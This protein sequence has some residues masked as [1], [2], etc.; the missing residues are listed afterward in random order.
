M[1]NSEYSLEYL[2][3]FVSL[4]WMTGYLSF[5]DVCAWHCSWAWPLGAGHG[6]WSPSIIRWSRLPSAHYTARTWPMGWAGSGSQ[7]LPVSGHW[8]QGMDGSKLCVVCCETFETFAHI[9]ILL[10]LQYSAKCLNIQ[11]VWCFSR[12]LCFNHQIFIVR[13]GL[14][15]YWEMVT[16]N[17]K[18]VYCEYQME[19]QIM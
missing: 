5:E 11:C 7:Q 17:P 16:W 18:K 13:L 12:N 19:V 10:E 15:D 3:F 6:Q 2:Y 14:N 1:Q 9:L 8:H 4:F